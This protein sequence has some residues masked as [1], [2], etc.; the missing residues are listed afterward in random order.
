MSHRDWDWDWD[1]A[2]ASGRAGYSGELVFVEK[3]EL[4]LEM[5]LR[6]LGRMH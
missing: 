1:W 4:I 3:D 5:Q 6:A 2:W